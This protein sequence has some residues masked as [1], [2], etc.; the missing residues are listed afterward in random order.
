MQLSTSLTSL[1][2][3]QGID[4]FSLL[5]YDFLVKFNTTITSKRQI[6]IPAALFKELGLAEGQQLLAQ[7]ANGQLIF[8]SM[9]ALIEQL[10]GS[11]PVPAEFKD[12]D[13][14]EIIESAKEAY[15]LEKY[16]KSL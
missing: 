2:E 9:T 15:F 3:L 7:V 12:K 8:R 5:T 10:Q 16:S 6:T 1:A 13:L 4:N 14:D 11:V